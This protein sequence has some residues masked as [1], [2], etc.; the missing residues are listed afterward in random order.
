[1]SQT[2]PKAHCGL[3]LIFDYVVP[4]G[5]GLIALETVYPYTPGA[6][7]LDAQPLLY[8]FDQCCIVLMLVLLPV[9]LYFFSLRFHAA[10]PLEFL[11]AILGHYLSPNQSFSFDALCLGLSALKTL[12]EKQH[13]SERLSYRTRNAPSLTLRCTYRKTA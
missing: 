4:S 6:P 12:F 9:H 11:Y 2:D 7:A 8:G 5:L 1:M 3:P 13:D 10:R